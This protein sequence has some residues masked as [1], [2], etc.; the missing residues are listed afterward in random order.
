MN[1]IYR[2]T[3]TANGKFYIGSTVNLAQ[4]WGRHRRELRRGVHKNRNMQASWNKH[5]EAAFTFETIENVPNVTQLVAAEQR[6]LD[7]VCDA[8]LCFNHNR[9]A[10]APW[11]GKSGAGTP[12][13]GRT[14]G[15]EI[16]AKNS[17]AKRG[18]NHPNWGKQLAPETKAKIS[19]ANETNPWRG[20][21]HTPEAIAKIAATSAGRSHT[22]QA[23]AKIST[24]L[25]GHEVTSTTR[26]KISRS[27]QGDGN[28]WYGKK[29]DAAFVDAISK[30][31]V[32]TAP[33]GTQTAYASVQAAREAL[34]L[35][36]PTITRALKSGKPIARGPRKG[37]SFAYAAG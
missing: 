2:I 6:W 28:Y 22:L 4:R 21:N 19:K 3:C 27:L 34:Y 15:P 24:A 17:A 20:A 10:D 16:R 7:Q 29:R 36:P 11:R 13:H 31:V 9:F 30:P 12:N 1:Y 8:P 37:W 18:E 32:A 5:G 35:L 23:R 25:Q 33:D 14:F 26:L